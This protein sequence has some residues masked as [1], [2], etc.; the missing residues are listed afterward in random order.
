LLEA[1]AAVATCVGNA[2]G[3]FMT[4]NVALPVS[5]GLSA[6]AGAQLLLFLPESLPPAK[7][8]QRFS[9]S[10]LLPGLELQIL[11]RTPVLLRLTLIIL[12]TGITD[13]GFGRIFPLALMRQMEWT[14]QDSYSL[15]FT[16]NI[17]TIICLGLLFQP[18]TL[19]FGNVGMLAIGRWTSLLGIVTALCV[20]KP[21]HVLTASAATVGPE[22]FSLPAIAGL[23]SSLVH[24]G[25]Q[26]AM[27]A[28]LSTAY[29]FACSLGVVLFG[30]I[31][32]ATNRT[33]L[34]GVDKTAFWILVASCSPVLVLIHSMSRADPKDPSALLIGSP[35]VRNDD[36]TPKDYGAT[37]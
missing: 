28:S 3:G 1:V 21:W 33:M 10:S 18:L 37:A 25:E 4:L 22:A 26:G 34:V 23:Q 30:A 20:T 2:I 11:W 9:W 31:F 32:D 19:V 35:E 14:S 16:G 12:L 6:L 5:F 13:K 36:L 17:S 27:Q 29:S 8:S 15:S 24:S 7:R